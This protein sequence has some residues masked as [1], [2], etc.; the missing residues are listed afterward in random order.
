M[1]TLNIIDIS[2]VENY[3]PQDRL[4]PDELQNCHAHY[5]WDRQVWE[6]AYYHG[7]REPRFPVPAVDYYSS[8]KREHI[9]IGNMMEWYFDVDQTIFHRGN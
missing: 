7:Y 8:T 1:T 2:H 4:V 5:R 6:V 9:P 3:C